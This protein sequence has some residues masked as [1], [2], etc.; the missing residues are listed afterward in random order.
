MSVAASGGDLRVSV[1]GAGGVPVVFVHGLGADLEVWRAQL[2][3]VRASGTRA[4]AYD[5][6]GHGGSDRPADGVY[7]IDALVD[8]LDHVVKALSLSRFVLVGHSLA[9]AVITSYAGAHPE[10][11][12]GLVYVDAVGSFEAIPRGDVR[13]FIAADAGRDADGVRAAYVEMLGSNARAETRQ[14]VLASAASLE[15]RAFTSLRRSMIE[16]PLKEAFARYHGPAIAIET[17]AQAP[18]FAASAALGVGRVV[19][20]NVSHWIMLDAPGSTN[21]ALDGFL[22]TLAR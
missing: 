7:T 14:R 18:P 20:P 9:G 2:D 21:S 16:A 17:G 5:Q 12:A 8:D 15:V 10:A 11:V 4:I 3:H 13:D 1:G 19:V 6:R 22:A